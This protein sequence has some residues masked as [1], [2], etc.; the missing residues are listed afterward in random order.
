MANSSGLKPADC[1]LNQGYPMEAI[2]I[3]N[4]LSRRSSGG[5]GC[6]GRD[7]CIYQPA[8][9]LSCPH[10]SIY[11]TCSGCFINCFASAKCGGNDEEVASILPAAVSST[12]N[13]VIPNSTRVKADPGEESSF[14]AAVTQPRKA[15]K[16]E[17]EESSV[18][19]YND[20]SKNGYCQDESGNK[21]SISKVT[22]RMNPSATAARKWWRIRWK[23]LVDDA[24][25]LSTKLVGQLCRRNRTTILYERRRGRTAP[26]VFKSI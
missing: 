11:K 25:Q 13:E 19:S 23:A 21:F 17:R 3:L 1:L 26:Q 24:Q 5:T 7:D 15:V 8:F 16:E 20:R 18:F 9:Q 4:E 12:Q 10:K 14:S 2:D 6:I 22:G